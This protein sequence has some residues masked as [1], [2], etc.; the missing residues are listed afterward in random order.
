M[1]KFV[2]FITEGQPSSPQ[3]FSH[4]VEQNTVSLI[5]ESMHITVTVPYLEWGRITRYTAE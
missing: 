1:D 5:V 2:E 4:D 3:Y